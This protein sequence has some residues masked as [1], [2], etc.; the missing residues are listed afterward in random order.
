MSQLLSNF[1]LKKNP[2]LKN[3]ILIYYLFCQSL[4]LSA[5]VSAVAKCGLDDQALL[6][7]FEAHYYNEVFADR[8]GDF[9]F[10]GKMIA[11]FRGSAG[12]SLSNKS[13]YFYVVKSDKVLEEEVHTWQARGTQL[14]ILSEEEKQFSGGYDAILISWSKMDRTA[15]AKKKL[16]KKLHKDSYKEK[17]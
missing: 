9:D 1:I 16:L 5:Q 11:Y 17:I 2:S 3:L 13:N 7:E 14:V 12:S 6:N 8:R 10:K 4:I 15:K